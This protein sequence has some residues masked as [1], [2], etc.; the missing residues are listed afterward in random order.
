MYPGLGPRCRGRWGRLG[1][2]FPVLQLLSWGRLRP[3][4]GSG[5]LLMQ[6]LGHIAAFHWGAPVP[7]FVRE[8]SSTQGL[9]A[10]VPGA[11]P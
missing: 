2:V 5:S 8:L 9:T 4:A 3:S 6:P 10:Q 1:G 7:P 11:P